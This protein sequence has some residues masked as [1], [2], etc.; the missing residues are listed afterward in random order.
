MISTIVP[1][2]RGANAG[3]AVT[4]SDILRGPAPYLSALAPT[5]VRN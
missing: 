3:P 1:E 4:E 5:G 2:R